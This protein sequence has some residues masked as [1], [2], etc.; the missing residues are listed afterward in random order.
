MNRRLDWPERLAEALEIAQQQTFSETYF[1]AA[2]SADVVL[3]MTDADPLPWRAGTLVEA[4]A[5]MREAGYE[6]LRDALAACV[7]E[8]VHVAHAHRGDVVLRVVDDREA[9]GICCGQ[10]S[11]FIS[12]EGGLAF[13]PT[14]E[15]VAAFRV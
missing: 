13:W 14:L 10:Q 9:I 12:S 7:G 1:C 8:E 4:Y 5:K 6:T 11:A 3:A 2:F 15:Q